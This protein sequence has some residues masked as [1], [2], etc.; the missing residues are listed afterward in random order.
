LA[1][2]GPE[3]NY[4]L[5]LPPRTG[6]NGIQDGY[7]VIAHLANQ[8]FTQEYI[9]VKLCRLFVHDDFPNPTTHTDLP[10]YSFYDYTDPYRSAEAELVHQCMLAWEN[11]S[12]KG[13]LR[14]VLNVI[15]NSELFRSHAAQA[16]KVKTPFEFVTSTVRALRGSTNGGSGFT[17]TTDGYAFATP[18]SRMGGMNLFDRDAP[19][20]YPETGPNWI[21]AGTLVE[22]IRFVQS[23]CILAGQTGHTGSQSGTGNDAGNNFCDP[24]GLMKDRLPAGSYG[25]AAAAVTDYFLGLLYPGGRRREPQAAIAPPASNFLNTDDGG[26][27]PPTF[28][29][30][31]QHLRHPRARVGRHVDGHAAI[32]RAITI[33]C[34]TS[35]S[36]RAAPS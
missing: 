18:L 35:T 11:S 17:A 8:P 20:G 16:Q 24:V 27:A 6:T 29:R 28:N 10:E 26:V 9:S 7:D 34:T 12:P 32:P 1:R 14:A 21:S 30:R 23:F 25:D 15:F 2:R 19:D 36:T 13:N 33:L 22:R 31:T 3:A 5:T 4:Q